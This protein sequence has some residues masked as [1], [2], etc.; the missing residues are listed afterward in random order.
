MKLTREVL[1]ERVCEA[2]LHAAT[3]LEPALE[4]RLEQMEQQTGALLD[5]LAED[6]G[7][8]PS[9]EASLEVLGMIRRNLALS[10]E[11]RLPMCQDTGMVVYFVEMGPDVALG[12]HEIES[13]LEEAVSS[14]VR[15]GNFRNSVVAEPLFERTNTG[16]NLPPV[17]HWFTKKEDGLTIRA[18]L[19]GFGS[20][21][22]SATRMLNPTSSADTVVDTIVEMVKA[23]GGKPCPPIVVGVGLGGTAER[24]ALLAKKA[25]LR[26]IGE[27]HPD[28]RYAQLES[29]T[30]AAIQHTHIGPGGFGGPLTTLGVAIEYE[31]THIAGMPLAVN[32][33]CW[34]DRKATVEFGGEDDA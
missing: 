24:A 10:A 32:I 3:H 13:A 19:K 22:C 25:L 31:P 33:S 28:P 29:Q 27:A 20:E 1:V 23:A 2:L 17:I 30:E 6:D 4:Q 14:A 15:Q 12:M 21:N 7:K 18:M 8:K 5:A 34:A 16:S 9:Y 11:T 26:P